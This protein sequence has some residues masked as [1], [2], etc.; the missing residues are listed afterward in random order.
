MSVFNIKTAKI[1]G[2]GD[3][4]FMV[5]K[6]VSP[7]GFRIDL[8]LNGGTCSVDH[9][10]VKTGEKYVFPEATKTSYVVEGWYADSK[11][12]NKVTE[13]DIVDYNIKKIYAKWVEA[14]LL[15]L[16]YLNGTK[17]YLT[18]SYPVLNWSHIGKTAYSQ[19][20]TG[21]VMAIDNG[22]SIPSIG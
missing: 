3:K 9:L 11:F 20:N 7:I 17:S 13:N 16:T 5:A 8:E 6:T 4:K 12:Q 10:D 15:T 14:N 2:T 19:S 22:A 18:G 21:I 1:E